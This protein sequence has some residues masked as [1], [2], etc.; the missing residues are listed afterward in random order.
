MLKYADVF[1]RI[2]VAVHDDGADTPTHTY[3][4]LHTQS[5]KLRRSSKKKKKKRQK[6]QQD[7]AI[8]PNEVAEIL[9]LPVVLS[10]L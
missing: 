1:L 5:R 6:Q 4:H 10:V 7:C 2:N 9:V 8:L 3:T